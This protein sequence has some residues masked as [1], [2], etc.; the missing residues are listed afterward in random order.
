MNIKTMLINLM[1]VSISVY[2]V[3]SKKPVEWLAMQEPMLSVALMI[4]IFMYLFITIVMTVKAIDYNQ[5][6][7]EFYQAVCANGLMLSIGLI[8][9]FNSELI[10]TA[11]YKP[12]V[13]A[14][15]FF[16]LAAAKILIDRNEEKLTRKSI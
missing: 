13:I 11:I 16:G 12:F 3:A 2:V 15:V 7:K 9:L 6:G 10:M 1:A 8:T 14:Y 5:K 4:L